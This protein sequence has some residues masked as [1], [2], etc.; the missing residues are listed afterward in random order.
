MKTFS[1]AAVNLFYR[2]FTCGNVCRTFVFFVCLAATTIVCHA[3]SEY[4]LNGFETITKPIDK[5]GDETLNVYS[6]AQNA[7]RAESWVISSGRVD[8]QGYFYET[9]PDGV[10]AECG[11]AF[12]SGDTTGDYKT[13]RSGIS[14]ERLDMVQF[15]FDSFSEGASDENSDAIVQLA[16]LDNDAESLPKADAENQLGVDA[17]F[18]HI[19]DHSDLLSDNYSDLFRFVGSNNQGQ[20]L[21]GR[22]DPEPL[23]VPESATLVLLGLG[24]AGLVCLRKLGKEISQA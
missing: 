6:E 23:P 1:D 15:E 8:C 20:F 5:S 9:V 12:S 16:L 14:F 3:K 19:I 17:N 4:R 18:A 24:V 10:V 2:V 13:S 22:S 11:T 21:I 7:V